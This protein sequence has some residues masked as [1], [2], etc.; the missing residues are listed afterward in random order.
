MNVLIDILL[1]ALFA[2]MAI[3]GFFKGF[4][5]MVLS[6]GRLVLAMV[7]TLV[8]GSAFS[9]WIDKTFVNPPIYEW[10]HG[11]L[12]ELAGGAVTNVDEFLNSLPAAFKGFV[13]SEAFRDK[14]GEAGASVDALVTDVS[15]SVSGAMSAVLA[16]VIG[17]ILLFAISFAILTVVIWLVGKFA[18][19]PILKSGDKLLGL[20]VGAVGGLIA[21]ALA[22]SVLYL[23]VYLTGDMSAY[24]NSVIFKFVKDINVFGFIFDKLLG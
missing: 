22:A 9:G 12:S 20:A 21:M 13:D 8:F 18:E 24:E 7:I 23:I 14:Y 15:T 6:F 19:L 2:F 16:T 11:K 3:R 10:V 17:Y 1:I 5:K 4:M